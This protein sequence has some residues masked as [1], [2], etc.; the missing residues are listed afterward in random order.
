MCAIKNPEITI[1]APNG[2]H[3]YRSGQVFVAAGEMDEQ[4]LVI[5]KPRWMWWA[6]DLYMLKLMYQHLML[7]G[8][9]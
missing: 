4:F 9:F 5:Q 7:T 2:V 6:F 1:I 3:I 8:R